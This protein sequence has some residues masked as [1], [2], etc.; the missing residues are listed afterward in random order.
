MPEN[1]Q[2]ASPRKSEVHNILAGSVSLERIDD[3][4]DEAAD[5][6]YIITKEEAMEDDDELE[7]SSL[8]SLD[9]GL[10]DECTSTSSDEIKGKPSIKGASTTSLDMIKKAHGKFYA[11]INEQEIPRKILHLSI[12][13]L[14]LYLY[15]LGHETKDIVKPLATTGAIIFSLDMLRFKSKKFN[16]AY[17]SVVG[18]MM[19]EKEVESVNGVIWYIIGCLISLTYAPKDVAVMS[20]LLLSWCDTAA[21]TVGRRFGYLTPKLARGKSLAG[22]MGAFVMGMIACY[23]F[24]GYL[25]PKYPQLN[26]PF[27]WKAQ[28]SKLSLPALAVLCGFIGALSEG[29]D[30]MELDDNL[31]IPAL[32]AIFLDGA[33]RL[34]KK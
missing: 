28:T 10:D 9:D 12:G 15:T 2:K 18:F 30:I 19:R 6:D 4:Y 21:S 24:Y 34:A 32:S 16:K 27:L 1:K 33:I 22:S 3:T 5:P 17:C 26:G 20:I 14:T 31:T 23:F 7:E 13:F 8:N 29:I 11:I 25:A